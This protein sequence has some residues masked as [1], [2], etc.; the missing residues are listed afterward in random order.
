MNAW[1][2]GPLCVSNLNQGTAVV[3]C[4]SPYATAKANL[5]VLCA[6]KKEGRTFAL[7]VCGVQH[8]ESGE[9]VVATLRYQHKP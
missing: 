6:T 7:R 2:A 3:F 9:N 8:E 4:T 1:T 5:S